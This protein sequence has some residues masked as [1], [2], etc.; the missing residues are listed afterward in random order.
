[1][2]ILKK[3]GHIF[4]ISIPVIREF[5]LFAGQE[6][7]GGGHQQREG[8]HQAGAQQKQRRCKEGED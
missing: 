6:V 7:P 1:M 3:K 2:T 8:N 5:Y 4:L